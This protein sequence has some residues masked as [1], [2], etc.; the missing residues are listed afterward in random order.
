MP[1]RGQKR[2][3]AEA[4]TSPEAPL[5]KRPRIEGGGV[6]LCSGINCFGQVGAGTGVAERKKPYYNKSF[7]E[8]HSVVDISAGG[9]HSVCLTQEGKVCRD[10]TPV[11]PALLR[12]HSLAVPCARYLPGAAVTKEHWVVW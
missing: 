12:C 3:L 10:A 4:D 6:V 1:P 9:M 11:R 8:E 5:P 7:H 2:T